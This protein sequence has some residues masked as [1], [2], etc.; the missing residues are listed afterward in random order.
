M[1]DYTTWL[2]DGGSYHNHGVFPGA[3]RP[4]RDSGEARRGRGPEFHSYATAEEIRACEHC[5]WPQGHCDTCPG[6]GRISTPSKS[7][8]VQA[9][10][11]SLWERGCQMGRLVRETGL[12]RSTIR[13]MLKR[14]G[15][16]ERD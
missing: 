1:I 14:W 3:C 8:E 11:R 15:I 16:Y 7:P 6:P 10:V 13:S 5:P 4:W 2:S 12:C 9:Q